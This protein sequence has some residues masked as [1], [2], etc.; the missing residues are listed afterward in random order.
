MADPTSNAA[1]PYHVCYRGPKG[2]R[3]YSGAA[4]QAD[5]EALLM[6]RTARATALHLPLQYFLARAGEVF[7]VG[8]DGCALPVSP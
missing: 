3:F 8:H 6:E 7:T 4:T 1:L 2:L 5:A